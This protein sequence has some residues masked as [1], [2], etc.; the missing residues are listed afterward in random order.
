MCIFTK[1]LIIGFFYHLLTIYFVCAVFSHTALF[2]LHKNVKESQK[3]I[4][5]RK[6]CLQAISSITGL[7]SYL[8]QKCSFSYK[9]IQTS[10]PLAAIE[11]PKRKRETQ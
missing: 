10:S 2:I 6:P 11:Q 7:F 3:C 1:L 8:N 9:S 4:A 5:L